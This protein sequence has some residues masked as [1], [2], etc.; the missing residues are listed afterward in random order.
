MV[1]ATPD[2]DGRIVHLV[3]P[4][5]T[6]WTIAAAYEIEVTELVALNNMTAQSFIFP[7]QEL[8]IA[9]DAEPEPSAESS[10]EAPTATTTRTPRPTSTPGP[11]RTPTAT[12]TPEPER[13]QLENPLSRGLVVAGVVI[14]FLAIAIG[15]WMREV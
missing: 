9:L 3:Q 14:V 2:E 5:Q 15:I 10:G 11:T 13:L 7:G 1:V 6:L 4:G 8:T 12:P